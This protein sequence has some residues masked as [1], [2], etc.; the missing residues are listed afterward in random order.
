MIKVKIVD[1]NEIFSFYFPNSD[2]PKLAKVNNDVFYLENDELE[3]SAKV[4]RVT[5]DTGIKYAYIQVFDIFDNFIE[6]II[7]DNTTSNTAPTLSFSVDPEV[8]IT[9]ADIEDSGYLETT[10]VLTYANLIDGLSFVNNKLKDFSLSVD[11]INYFN[12]I[13]PLEYFDVSGTITLYIRRN[14][15]GFGFFNDTI[16]LSSGTTTLDINVKTFTNT[17][18]VD[19]W[20]TPSLLT[21]WANYGSPYQEARYKRD[22]NNVVHIQGHVKLGTSTTIFQ[23]P[24]YCRPSS[25]M[26][27]PVVEDDGD[28][29]SCSYIEVKASGEVIASSFG[30]TNLSLNICFML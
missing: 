18:S 15:N 17:K 22:F 28:V 6:D 8:T 27:F 4:D 9:D 16:E 13:I 2:T 1:T 3:F 19:E 23:L 24:T 29:T 7:V 10:I 12:E 21:T 30:L 26:L 14:K 11:G 20:Q 25:Q 5:K